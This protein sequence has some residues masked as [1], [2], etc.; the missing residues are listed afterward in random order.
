MTSSLNGLR[1]R[2]FLPAAVLGLLS[3]GS[4]PRAGIGQE[5][6][7]AEARRAIGA[8]TVVLR[9][10]M[11]E[12]SMLSGFNGLTGEPSE[13]P[14]ALTVRLLLPDFYLNTQTRSGVTYLRGFRRA[15]PFFESRREGSLT[16][17]P[18]E[19][20]HL[21]SYQSDV[22]RLLLGMFG[23][24]NGVLPLTVSSQDES[25]VVVAGGDDGFEAFVDLD[26]E[27]GVPVRV[28]YVDDI[29]YPSRPL[30]SADRSQGRLPPVTRESA[31]V[32]LSFG[33]RRPVDGIAVPHLIR[34]TA[35]GRRL[36]ELRLTRVVVNPPLGS[37]DFVG[38]GLVGAKGF[39]R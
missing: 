29:E 35:A 26:S 16:Q 6:G 33:D 31:E 10:L 15:A 14:R 37:S 11:F 39:E 25:L 34:K 21:R 32:T 24:A 30:S 27:T 8:D 36:E 17:M 12:G 38:S 13:T 23:V 28:R 2:I 9:S 1:V 3:F 7:L 19:T 5:D 18:L 22:A 4:P 20:S